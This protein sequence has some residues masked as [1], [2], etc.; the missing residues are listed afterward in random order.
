ML[1]FLKR[2]FFYYSKIHKITSQPHSIRLVFVGSLTSIMGSCLAHG[3]HI[4][5]TFA[6]AENPSLIKTQLVF[7][8]QTIYTVLALSLHEEE[9]KKRIVKTDNVI[10]KLE[11]MVR[12]T[13]EQLAARRKTRDKVFSTCLNREKCQE[14]LC[15]LSLTNIGVFCG[16]VVRVLD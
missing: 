13:Q 15:R 6:E 5:L 2:D 10:A 16:V 8:N 12:A 11:S 14:F 4:K 3:L 1:S 9:V 7:G